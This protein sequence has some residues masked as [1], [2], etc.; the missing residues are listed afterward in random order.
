M[1]LR[2]QTALCAGLVRTDNNLKNLLGRA[3]MRFMTCAHAL[4][5]PYFLVVPKWS[6]TGSAVSEIPWVGA[7]G[8]EG[9]SKPPNHFDVRDS[10]GTSLSATTPNRFNS[11]SVVAKAVAITIFQK[12]SL[13]KTN[14]P[15]GFE[16]ST[17]NY[18]RRS[19]TLH[20]ISSFK[21]PP[22]VNSQSWRCSV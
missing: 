19:H 9:N 6:L 16:L 11:K 14:Q 20:F 3:V 22:L 2:H 1:S 18:L 10:W 5:A 4:C 17:S 13:L 15:T 12:K 7:V 8:F 21:V